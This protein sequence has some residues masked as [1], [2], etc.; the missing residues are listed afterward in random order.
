MSEILYHTFDPVFDGIRACSSSAHVSVG[1]VARAGILLR[2]PA[3]P[4]LEGALRGVFLARAAEH[5]GEKEFAARLRSC[6]LGWSRRA[7]K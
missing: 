5:G 6:A 1:E 3:K 2:Q 4:L 7:A